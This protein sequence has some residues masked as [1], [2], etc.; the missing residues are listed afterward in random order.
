MSKYAAMLLN[1]VSEKWKTYIV[2]NFLIWIKKILS[3]KWINKL[4]NI[5][6]HVALIVTSGNTTE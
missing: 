3:S 2:C 5:N 1:A 4:E 6:N